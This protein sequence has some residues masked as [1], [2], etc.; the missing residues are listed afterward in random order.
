MREGSQLKE[1]YLAMNNENTCSD[2]K[3]GKMDMKD[4][5]IRMLRDSFEKRLLSIESVA[6]KKGTP[7]LIQ[8]RQDL[9][10]CFEEYLKELLVC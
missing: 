6:C 4:K 7:S 10:N 2:N 1:R 3:C 5:A 8:K 9:L